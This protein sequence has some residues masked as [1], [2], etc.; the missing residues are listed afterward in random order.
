M[1]KIPV[2]SYEFESAAEV[3]TTS[4][5]PLLVDT[6]TAEA[7]A[8]PGQTA[9]AAAALPAET[10]ASIPDNNVDKLP[11]DEITLDE[12]ILNF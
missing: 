12:E 4:L 6:N 5:L 2:E 10:S 8:D 9:P 7:P 1:H 3:N 11:E